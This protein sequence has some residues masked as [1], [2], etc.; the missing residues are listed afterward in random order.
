[1]GKKYFFTRRT[2]EPRKDPLECATKKAE[3]EAVWTAREQNP[4][5]GHYPAQYLRTLKALN[6]NPR[7]IYYRKGRAAYLRYVEVFLQ[8]LDREMEKYHPGMKF[9]DR[10]TIPNW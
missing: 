4:F 5:Q 2:V 7:S 1:M 9:S 10:K 8:V 6:D 3:K